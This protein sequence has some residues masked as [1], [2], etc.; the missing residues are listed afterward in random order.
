MA[1][2]FPSSFTVYTIEEGY[3]FDMATLPSHLKAMEFAPCLA[4]QSWSMGFI[5]PLGNGEFVHPLA[6]GAFMLSLYEQEKIIPNAEIARLTSEKVTEL[7]KSGE[8]LVRPAERAALRLEIGLELRKTALSK[9]KRYNVMVIPQAKVL[10]VFASKLTAD[11]VTAQIRKAIGTLRIHVAKVKRDIKLNAL[12]GLNHEHFYLSGDINF[13][14]RD[15]REANI[16]NFDDGVQIASY[17]DDDFDIVMA[18][19]KLRDLFNF[20]FS[21]EFYISGIRWDESITAKSAIEHDTSDA[22]NTDEEAMKTAAEEK[23]A[24]NLL[25]LSADWLLIQSSLMNFCDHF[26]GHFGG[27]VIAAK[28]EKPESEKQ[29]AA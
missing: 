10:V 1:K 2:N 18:R 11:D 6:G 17:L 24:R 3:T 19:I 25:L 15:G 8:T 5:S 21:G 22:K 28:R 12:H 16:K 29:D 14:N 26:A 27:F 13:E 4:D 20:K 23:A 7:E 9:H